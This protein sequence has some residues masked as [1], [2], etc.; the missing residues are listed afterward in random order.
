LT[1]ADTVSP[2]N[3]GEYE[4]WLKILKNK[5]HCLHHGYYMTRLPVGPEEMKQGWKEAR[6]MEH[7]F[8]QGRKP[9]NQNPEIKSR[10]GTP[11]LAEALSKRLSTMIEETLVP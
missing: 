9:W 11:K 7:N 5:S 4:I 1:K 8:F 6:Q 2:T 3:D 10:L